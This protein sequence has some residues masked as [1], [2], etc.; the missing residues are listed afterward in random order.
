MIRCRSLIAMHG[1]M[2]AALGV[3]R[4]TVKVSKWEAAGLM[5]ARI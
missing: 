5:H 3:S 1:F 4:D 2:Y